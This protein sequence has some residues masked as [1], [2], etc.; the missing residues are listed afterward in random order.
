MKNTTN[1]N[2]AKYNL[3]LE[4]IEICDMDIIMILKKKNVK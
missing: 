2:N 1:A 4:V 3:N